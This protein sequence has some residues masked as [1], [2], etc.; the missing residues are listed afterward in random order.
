MVC[1]VTCS[2]MYPGKVEEMGDQEG[3]LFCFIH[4]FDTK[5]IVC[6]IEEPVI[7]NKAILN[8]QSTF[9]Q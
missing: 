7:T 5:Q 8:S 6:C 1:G 4:F 9:K 3:F 2:E